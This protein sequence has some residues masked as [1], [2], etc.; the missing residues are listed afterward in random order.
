L[1]AAISRDEGIRLLCPAS[2]QADASALMADYLKREGI[3]AEWV[4]AVSHRDRLLYTLATAVSDTST[5]DLQARSGYGLS[6]VVVR[7]PSLHGKSRSSLTVSRQEILLALMQHGRV[8]DFVGADCGVIALQR[9]VELRQNIV[10]WAWHLSW[11]WPDGEA[12]EWNTRYWNYGTP[13]PR[14]PLVRAVQD[15]FDQQGRYAVGCY[16]AT[17]LTLIQ[18]A[19]DYHHRV[20]P[21]GTE[22]ARLEAKLKADGEPLQNIEPGRLWDFEADFDPAERHR[23]GKLTKI[24][25]GVAAKNF[26]P[27]DWVV[28]VNTDPVSY[29][30]T[31]YEGSNAIYLG[32][33][34]FDDY[35]NDHHHAYTYEEKLDEVYQWRHGVF[36]RIRDSDKR[37]PLGADDFERLSRI[38]AAGGLVLDVRV[39]PGDV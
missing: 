4:Q 7:L 32:G 1:T 9:E 10:A 37:H 6:D 36:S 5:L 16:T 12:A 21:D 30:K 3:A 38:P 34:R 28:F 24:V 25:D 20:R 39:V 18:A 33:G 14:V 11:T 2:Q 27:G 22:L 13:H 23:P 31:G 26:V 29:T 15:A 35:Y 17:K 19:L 8:T